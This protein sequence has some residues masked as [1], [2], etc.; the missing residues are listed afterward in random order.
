[1]GGETVGEIGAGSLVLVGVKQEDTPSDAH[2]LA[3]KIAHLR[4]FDD[5][6]GRMELSAV[7]TG[8]AV[9][10]VSQFT[11][12]GDVRKGRRPSY[13]RA[14]SGAAAEALYEEVCEQLRR[15]GVP[16]ATGRFG[17]EMEVEMIGDGPVTLLLDS[18]RVF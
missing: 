16:V 13:A 15:T 18:E 4:I 6:Q 10:V 3:E 14:A 7:E 12:F 9:L 8:M 11:L 1:V 2:Y 17:A 5:A